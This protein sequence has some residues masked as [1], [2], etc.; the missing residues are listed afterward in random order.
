MV[1]NYESYAERSKGTKKSESE[2]SEEASR[3][4]ITIFSNMEKY[5]A[6]ISGIKIYAHPFQNVLKNL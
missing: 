5:E 2:S 1:F 4:A 6:L 3:W